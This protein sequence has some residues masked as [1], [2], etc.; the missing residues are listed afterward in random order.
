M[1]SICVPFF[2]KS[3]ELVDEAVESAVRAMS[4]ESELLVLPN[5]ADAC[6]Q[7]R[8]IVLPN[9]VRVLESEPVLSQA[10]NW[11]RC[12]SLSKGELIHILH[13]DDLVMPEFYRAILALRER[14]PDASLYATGR[15]PIDETTDIRSGEE[16]ILLTGDRAAEFILVD[17]RY[18]AGCVVMSRQA[19]EAKGPFRDGSYS[20]D[21]E[22]FLRQASTGGIAL[23]PT[24]LYRTR[25]H[26]E[27]VRYATWRQPDWAEAYFRAR[28]GGASKYSPTAVD[29]ARRSSARRIIS[30]AVSLALEGERKSALHHLD[31]LQ[32]LVP[33]CR[34]W[35]RFWLARATAKSRLLR[36]VAAARRKNL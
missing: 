2:G 23:D 13:H 29:L 17:R 34:A 6:F 10:E 7:L 16:T 3:A 14:F 5:G 19:V 30:V 27:Q 22:A 12:L 24:P 15:A 28:V 20:P 11:N 33:G 8:R 25:S 4:E 36:G 1:L 31:E 32:R 9:I 18:F 21:E 35:P 26:D